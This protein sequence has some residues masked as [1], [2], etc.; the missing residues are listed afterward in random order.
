MMDTATKNSSTSGGSSGKMD[1]MFGMWGSAS[2]SANFQ[3]SEAEMNSSFQESG[4]GSL[5][6]DSKDIFDASRRINCSIH[7]SSSETEQQLTNRVS[8]SIRIQHIPGLKEKMMQ[9]RADELDKIVALREFPEIVKIVMKQ[10]DDLQK[11]INDLGSINIKNSVI[12]A[13]AGSKMRT[14]S[15]NVTTVAN[16]LQADYETIVEATANNTIQQ[17]AGSNAMQPEVK[18]I[19]RERIQRQT[20]E[21]NSDITQT[22]SHTR[23]KVL[24]SSSIVIIAPNKID[25]TNVVLDA[26]SE[27]DMITSA[28]T[29]SSVDLGKRIASELMASAVSKNGMSTEND[30]LDKVVKEMSDGNALNTRTQNEG[31][32]DVIEANKTQISM[33]IIGLIVAAIAIPMVMKGMNGMNGTQSGNGGDGGDG[34]NG[35]SMPSGLTPAKQKKWKARRFRNRMIRIFLGLLLKVIVFVNFVRL[36]PRLIN[37]FLPWK[38]SE[39]G[40]VIVQIVV[41]IV[42]LMAYCI[43]INKS[44]NPVMCLIKF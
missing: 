16:Q 21:I 40:D 36:G 26:S 10:R 5:L 42:I 31:L 33:G 4:C 24:N 27:I 43:F 35:L 1:V 37:I 12:K 38:W 32:A 19:I 18:Q 13:K 20:D 15:Q 22:L 23:I 6:F 3:T 7:Q 2:A 8:V 44:L 30:G 11:S 17:Q 41:N 39:L 25:L 9:Q 34:R 28:L 14:M 29:S